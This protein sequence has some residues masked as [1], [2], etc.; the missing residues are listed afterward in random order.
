MNFINQTYADSLALELFPFSSVWYLS[1]AYL[2]SFSNLFLPFS[3]H[4][5]D[6]P[7]F[8]YRF[9]VCVFF[10]LDVWC[11]W[12]RIEEVGRY[13]LLCRSMSW[14]RKGDGEDDGREM[15]LVAMICMWGRRAGRLGRIVRLWARR[16]CGRALVVMWEGLL[17]VVVGLFVLHEGKARSGMR[18]SG[19]S[20]EV[21]KVSRR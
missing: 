11:P 14:S 13:R 5:F 7:F 1:F 12:K 17:V 16:D 15:G 8:L 2:V 19:A 18:E 20:G 9:T 6:Y 21:I 10:R 4:L 3:L